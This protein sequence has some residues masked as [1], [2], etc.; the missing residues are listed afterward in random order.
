MSNRA[1]GLSFWLDSVWLDC[2]EGRV[3]A[4]IRPV[5]YPKPVQVR[6]C[7]ARLCKS[8]LSVLSSRFSAKSP[9]PCFLTSE[10][11]DMLIL[12]SLQLEPLHGYAV[13]K[14]IQQLSADVLRVEEGSLYPALHRMEQRGWIAADWGASANN[15]KAKFYSL[16]RKGRQQLE[17]ET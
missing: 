1:A 4:Q 11:P 15:R 7:G 2:S 9:A 12:K 5:N 13:A 14:R 10:T 6:I 17:G 8:G 16:T 3:R